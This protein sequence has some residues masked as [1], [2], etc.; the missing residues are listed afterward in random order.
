M[1]EQQRSAAA[2]DP[3]RPPLCAPHCATALLLAVLSNEPVAPRPGCCMLPTKSKAP[4][5]QR[6]RRVRPPIGR[7][8]SA[9]VPHAGGLPAG[10]D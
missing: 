3:S 8:I 10:D 6:E 4:V 9:E 5:R 7:H 2:C 1:H